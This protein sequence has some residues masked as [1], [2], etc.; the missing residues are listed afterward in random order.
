MLKLR[1]SWRATSR[2]DES[3]PPTQRPE[4]PEW[5]SVE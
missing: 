2:S 5:L 4:C 1:G 3:T